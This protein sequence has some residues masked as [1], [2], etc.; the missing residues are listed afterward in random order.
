MK[1]IKSLLEMT[2]DEHEADLRD[3]YGSL[4]H[5]KAQ[6]LI[7]D[8]DRSNSGSSSDEYTEQE[9]INDWCND[10]KQEIQKLLPLAY[11]ADHEKLQ[12][13]LQKYFSN[14]T[15]EEA[16][17]WAATIADYLVDKYAIE[18]P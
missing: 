16:A 8:P 14:S 9:W 10:H 1:L 15:S 4:G 18:I 6:S 13:N 3:A 11:K 5:P 12:A 2:R 17:Y 7:T